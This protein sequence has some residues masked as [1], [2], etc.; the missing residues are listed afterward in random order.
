MKE[1]TNITEEEKTIIRNLNN[2]MYTVEY[3]EEWINK[4]DDVKINA[5]AALI[6]CVAKGYYG[7]IKDMVKLDKKINDN[8]SKSN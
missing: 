8:N 1:H 5:V 6:S 4:D 2:S 7:A 3:I